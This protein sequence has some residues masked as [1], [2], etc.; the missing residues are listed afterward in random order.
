MGQFLILNQ[1]SFSKSIHSPKDGLTKDT[2][3]IVLPQE[4]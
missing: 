2:S 4:I 3:T 1:I